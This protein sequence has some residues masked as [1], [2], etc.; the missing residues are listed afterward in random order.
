LGRDALRDGTGYRLRGVPDWIWEIATVGQEVIVANPRKVRL[1]GESKKDDRSDAQ[2]SARL[3][4]ANPKMP[5]KARSTT[6]TLI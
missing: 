6:P 3:A 4:G 2:T 5:L 1:I